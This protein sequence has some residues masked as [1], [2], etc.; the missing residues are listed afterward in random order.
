VRVRSYLGGLDAV[1]RGAALPYGYTLTTWC[2]ADILTSEHGT[3]SAWLAMT[4]VAAALVAFGTLKFA[5]QGANPTT[6]AMQLADDTHVLRAG[7]AHV[8]AIAAA[9][10]AVWLL[11]HLHSNASWALGGFAAT[12]LY[13]LGTAIELERRER[14]IA[15]SATDAPLPTPGDG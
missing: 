4:Y 2:S 14:A 6:N 13:L 12:A 1:L 7:L 3:P 15:T 10:G 8:S 11:A 9:L 5:A